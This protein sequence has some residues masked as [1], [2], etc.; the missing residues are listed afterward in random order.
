MKKRY[1]TLLDLNIHNN[2]DFES[3]K[4]QDPIAGNNIKEDVIKEA[5]QAIEYGIKAK[6][7]TAELFEIHNTRAILNIPKS[8]WKSTLNNIIL[9]HFIEK[10][11]YTICSNIRDLISQI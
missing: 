4:K 3:I 1:P 10:E 9:P 7:Q 8:R 2:I 5:Y 11:E 6:K